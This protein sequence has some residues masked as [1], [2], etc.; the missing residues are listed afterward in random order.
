MKLI[1]MAVLMSIASLASAECYQGVAKDG[2]IAGLKHD[3]T[4]VF[5]RPGNAGGNGYL[6]ALDKKGNNVTGETRCSGG[7]PD[8]CRFGTDGGMGKF[9]FLQ[10][11]PTI[12]LD[13]SKLKVIGGDGD[14]QDLRAVSQNGPG[15]NYPLEAADQK[16]CAALFPQPHEMHTGQPVKHTP[17]VSIPATR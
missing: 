2:S 8:L 13:K 1:F 15:F 14:E 4:L 7:A 9:Q 11:V 6:A 3:A 16:V 17:A 5:Q 12:V 10:N